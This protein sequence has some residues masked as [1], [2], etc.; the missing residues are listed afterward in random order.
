MI[1]L[2]RLVPVGLQPLRRESCVSPVTHVPGND[3][4][5]FDDRDKIMLADHASPSRTAPLHLLTGGK[6]R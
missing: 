5:F 1:S 3:F 2:W 4:Y 6:D